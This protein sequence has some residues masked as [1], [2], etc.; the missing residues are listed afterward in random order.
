MGLEYPE[1]AAADWTELPTGRK[2][3]G[4]G[5]NSPLSIEKK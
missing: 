3:L 5:G 1:K 2:V 4:G